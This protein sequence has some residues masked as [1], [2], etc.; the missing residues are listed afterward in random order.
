MTHGASSPAPEERFT[1]RVAD[2]VRFR[3]GYPQSLSTLLSEAAGLGA[4]MRVADLGSGTGIFSRF[5]LTMGL[6]VYAVEPNAAMRQAGANWLESW[7]AFHSIA[8]RAEDTG[9]PDQ[10]MDAVLAAQAFHWFDPDACRQESLRILRPGAPAVLLWN[11]RRLS[12]SPFLEGYEALLQKFGTDYAEVRH[13]RA[14]AAMG[15]FFGGPVQTY[16]LPN[17]QDLDRA[18]LEGRVASSSYMPGRGHPRHAA[19]M[20]ALGALFARHQVGRRVRL[21]YDTQVFIGRLDG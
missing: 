19:M 17:H 1:D 13:D 21:E 9:L 6:E 4:G 2:Y 11:A 3:P 18:G 7:P 16:S 14:D 20:G 5:L 15:R 8:A 10:S 12:G